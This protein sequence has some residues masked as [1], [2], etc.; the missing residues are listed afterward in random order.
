MSAMHPS[1]ELP[2]RLDITGN[3]SNFLPTQGDGT[4]KDRCLS[5][6]RPELGVLQ[7]PTLSSCTP[8]RAR[9]LKPSLGLAL[10]LCQAGRGTYG[11][12]RKKHS[13]QICFHRGVSRQESV[14]LFGSN[15]LMLLGKVSSLC[16]GVLRH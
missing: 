10:A 1:W 15:L 6:K 7:E 4:E 13:M 9:V 5:Q 8:S 11:S 3:M 2:M 12:G 14:G 16:W